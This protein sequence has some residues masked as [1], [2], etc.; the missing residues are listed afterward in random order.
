MEP[1]ETPDVMCRGS[2]EAPPTP[3]TWVRPDRQFLNQFSSAFDS[4]K[5]QFPQ[6]NRMIYCIECLTQ[7][8]KNC[9]SVAEE[10]TIAS[11]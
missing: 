2:D 6:Q 1:C 11:Y 3:T 10:E 8:H 9:S 4:K 5:E 7:V